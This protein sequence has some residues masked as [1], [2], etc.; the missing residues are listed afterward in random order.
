VEDVDVESANEARAHELLEEMASAHAEAVGSIASQPA[1]LLAAARLIVQTAGAGGKIMTCGNGGSAADAQHL[2][3]ELVGRFEGPSMSLPCIALCVDTAVMTAL[4]NDYGYENV[5]AQQVAA[6][7]RPGDLL[8][9]FSTSGT[10][11]NVLSA[12]RE[13]RRLGMQVVGFTGSGAAAGSLGEL[14]DVAVSC[15]SSE[16]PRIQEAHGFAVHAVCELVRALS[17]A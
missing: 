2:A 17:R 3:A 4:A 7:G 8:I 15:A 12:A 11:A 9:G 5:F 16:T 13:A 6:L 1:T 14:A 10:S